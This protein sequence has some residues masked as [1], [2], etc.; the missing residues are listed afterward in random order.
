MSSNTPF[1]VVSSFS[2]NLDLNP[3]RDLFI[4]LSFVNTFVGTAGDSFV[5]HRYR[6]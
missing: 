4:V 5:N 2:N 3:L 1:L 6:K